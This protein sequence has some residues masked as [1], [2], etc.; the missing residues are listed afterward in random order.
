MVPNS[1]SLFFFKWGVCVGV[2]NQP[3]GCEVLSAKI[4]VSFVQAYV[5]PGPLKVQLFCRAV[6]IVGTFLFTVPTA[7]CLI[8]PW[9]LWAIHFLSHCRCSLVFTF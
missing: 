2:H 9:S 5:E 6:F 3:L 4:G 7:T 8:L 1:S